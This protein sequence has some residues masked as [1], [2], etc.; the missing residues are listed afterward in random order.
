MTKTPEELAE[1]YADYHVVKGID[2]I[3]VHC[4]GTIE[5]TKNAWLSGYQAA[6]EKYEARIKEL[7]QAIIKSVDAMAG[8]QYDDENT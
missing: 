7:E 3:R 4:Q 5:R 2:F 6:K 1:E 8:V